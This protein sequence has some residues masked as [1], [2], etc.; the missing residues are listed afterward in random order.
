MENCGADTLPVNSPSR[1]VKRPLKVDPPSLDKT[2]PRNP[3][4]SKPL[5]ALDIPLPSI[6]SE[7]AVRRLHN[8]PSGSKPLSALDISLPS[9]PSEGA[10]HRLRNRS[11][12][13][14]SSGSTFHHPISRSDSGRFVRSGIKVRDVLLR[15]TSRSDSGKF[16]RSGVLLHPTSKNG[17]EAASVQV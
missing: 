5:S 16:V 3:S 4:G 6:P 2:L 13:S 1:K 11:D 7:G 12:S 10:V 15:P 17:D 8:R 9:I 14:P